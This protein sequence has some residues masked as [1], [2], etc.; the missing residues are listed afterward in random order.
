MVYCYNAWYILNPVL[1]LSDL[2]TCTHKH[3]AQYSATWNTK[4]IRKVSH[5][6]CCSSSL[7]KSNFPPHKQIPDG[8]DPQ[9]SIHLSEKWLSNHAWTWSAK[10]CGAT[11][12]TKWISSWL[13]RWKTTGNTTP[14]QYH[15]S[16]SQS[17]FSAGISQWK[18]LHGKKISRYLCVRTVRSGNDCECN[19]PNN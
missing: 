4:S 19:Q 17:T 2:H 15:V 6:C 3:T 1:L 10:C 8:E 16:N 18:P 7:F 9:R 12:F 11:W 13:F 14:I 5:I